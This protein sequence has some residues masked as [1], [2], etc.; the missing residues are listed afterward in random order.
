MNDI[1][2]GMPDLGFTTEGGWQDIREIR[3]DS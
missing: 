2:E 3:H 1:L